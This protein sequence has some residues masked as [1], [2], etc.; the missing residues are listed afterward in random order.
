MD[1]NILRKRFIVFLAI[2]LWAPIML[3]GIA[4]VLS[5][6][7]TRL[8][9]ASW[10]EINTSALPLI[11]AIIATIYSCYLLRSG[12][13]DQ[14]TRLFTSANLA[15][16]MIALII[17][18]RGSPLQIEAQFGLIATIALLSGWCD[19]KATAL[20]AVIAMFFTISAVAI[21][22]AAAFTGTP[23][24]ILIMLHLLTIFITLEGVNRIVKNL[25]NASSRVGEALGD[26]M[27]ATKR[28]EKLADEQKHSSERFAVERKERLEE[29]ANIFKERTAGFLSAVR[30]GASEMT[31]S[32][33]QLTDIA[34]RTAQMAGS[35]SE[36]SKSTNENINQLASASEQLAN[37]VG[38][39]S[40]QVI[41]TSTAV[42]S[43]SEQAVKSSDRVG[44]LTQAAKQIGT[45]INLISDIAEQTNL[46]ALNATIESARAGESGK[47]FAVV[48]AE[49]KSL[50]EQTSQATDQ[51]TQHIQEIQTATNDTAIEINEIATMMASVDELS[52]S[53]S[54]AIEEQGTVT[55]EISA[56]VQDTANYSHTLAESV[57]GVDASAE[58]TNTSAQSVHHFSSKLEEDADRLQKEIDKFL[59]ELAA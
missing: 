57:A 33:V 13:L 58:E 36:S 7:M 45:V 22:P 16:N 59:N 44:A 38:E 27:S 30:T 53:I 41:K 54:S 11:I 48:A 46:L 43:A 25:E 8:M 14:N 50:A 10:S 5:E 2:L 3:A 39:I 51:I 17:M 40:G 56:N 28:A 24:A 29:V 35:A 37:S 20:A 1:L 4:F 52:S 55:N 19:K 31:G 23:S 6:K 32:A 15:L 26:A 47:G 49:V 9:P 21:D 18:L 42:R 12:K 34:Q